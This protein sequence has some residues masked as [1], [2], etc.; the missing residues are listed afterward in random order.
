MSGIDTAY[1][2]RIYHYNSRKPQIVIR[3]CSKKSQ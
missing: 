3:H 1:V 2:P